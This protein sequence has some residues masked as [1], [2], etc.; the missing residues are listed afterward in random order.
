MF[1]YQRLDK[2]TVSELSKLNPLYSTLALLFEWAMIFGII[3]VSEAYFSWLTY[4]FAVLLLGG[5]YHA[6]GVLAHEAAHYRLF[7]NRKLNDWIGEVLAWPLLTTLHGYR[8]N[9]LIHHKHANSDHD[10]DWVRKLN[11]PFFQFP[12][13]KKEI[14]IA[15]LKAISGLV[16]IGYIHAI[17][18]S[19]ELND[20]PKSLK[21]LRGTFYLTVVGVCVA[22]NV[23]HA[24]LMYWMIP[25]MTS[26]SLVMYIRSVA[27]HHGGGMNYDDELGASRHVDATLFEK[28]F[29]PHNINYHLDHHLYPSVPYYKLP[30]L[31][32]RLLENEDYRTRAHI[33]KGYMSGLYNECLAKPA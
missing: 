19:K 20:V 8:A 24:L 9:H 28:L 2:K 7:H 31:H 13:S 17:I 5:R 14:M 32:Q 3:V 1:D 25:L 30:A 23:W 33:T 15:V 26:F 6:L 22:L 18:L 27:E 10:P 11:D 29:I 4:V 21:C 12:K 16:F